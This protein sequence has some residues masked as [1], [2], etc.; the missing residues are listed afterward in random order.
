MDDPLEVALTVDPTFLEVDKQNMVGFLDCSPL[1]EESMSV[2]LHD[3]H[4][5]NIEDE[6]LLPWL[7]Y[8]RTFDSGTTDSA[9][10]PGDII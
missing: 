7:E 10:F 6:S 9:R 3:L 5:V 2:E 4:R 8:I 1:E